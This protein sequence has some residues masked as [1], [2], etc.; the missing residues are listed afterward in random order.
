M[1]KF[2]LATHNKNKVKEMES[3]LRKM[4]SGI[5]GSSDVEFCVLTAEDVGMTD[6]I[7]ENGSTFEENARIKASSLASSEWYAVAD[8]SGLE[9][10]ALNGAPGVYSA[11]YS[12][13]G[14]R[15]NNEKLLAELKGVPAGER[16]ARFVS[17]ICCVMPDGREIMCRGE[18]EGMILDSPRGEGGFGYD[19]LFYYAPLGKTLAELTADEKNSISHRGRA[20]ERFSL[21]FEP[22]LASERICGK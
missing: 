18:C 21:L 9:V 11:R 12:G 8:D 17:A 16:T 5:S 20:L 3:I 1:L 10:D 15:E 19:P 2:V 7:E 14:D 4:L 13:G 22:E 6:D